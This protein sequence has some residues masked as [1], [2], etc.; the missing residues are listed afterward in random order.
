MEIG[1]LNI[2]SIRRK[3]TA[4]SH[5]IF[6]NNLHI[7]GIVETWNTSNESY[8]IRQI[9]PTGFMYFNCPRENR[10]GGGLVL[11]A[12]QSF[13]ISLVRHICFDY[14]E[15]ALFTFNNLGSNGLL[16]LVYRPPSANF[17]NFITELCNFFSELLP[18]C[19]FFSLLR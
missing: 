17:N 9:C 2:R 7:F 18:N 1:I 16:R 4:H 15:A 14:L 10:S 3:V 12:H 19:H 5:I 8:L 13:C 6:S 11:I